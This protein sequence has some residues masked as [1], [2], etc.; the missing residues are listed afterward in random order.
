MS[1]GIATFPGPY[2]VSVP[3]HEATGNLVISYS[4]NEKDFPL[5]KYA[6]LIPVSKVQGLYLKIT[7]EEAGRLMQDGETDWPAGAPRPS[8]LGTTE[9]HA[10]FDYRI[11]RKAF[12]V[13]LD[14]I[15]VAEATW[16]IMQTHVRIKAQAAMTRRTK[17]AVTALTTSGN[18]DSSHVS[19]IAAICGSGETW[20]G[21]TGTTLNIKKSIDYAM[22]KI[23]QDSL[24]AVKLEDMVLVLNP[25]LAAAMSITGELRDYL[26]SSVYSGQVVKGDWAGPSSRGL[27][28]QLYG[29]NVVV[30]NTSQTTSR[31]GATAAKSYLMGN[32][33]AALVARPGSLQGFEGPQFSTLSMFVHK[34][35]DMLVEKIP[36]VRDKLTEV[37]IVDGTD[38]QIT[39]PVT[40][41]LFTSCQ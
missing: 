16:D 41:F 40:G 30:E 13:P 38:S 10:Y 35:M 6:K 32:A 12:T 23:E 25:S 3:D 29:V 22:N 24:S 11:N 39:A 5:N 31:R 27:P 7:N 1:S 28:T 9:S 4:R 37:S 8:G 14:D 26:K 34:E 19:T 33:V 17:Q 21:S 18:Y 2:N 36:N 15:T 20:A